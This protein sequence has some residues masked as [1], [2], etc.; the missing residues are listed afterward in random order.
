MQKQGHIASAFD[1]D[2]QSIQA[3]I[4]KMG[5]LVETAIAD[6]ARALEMRDVELAEQVRRN[7]KLIDALEEEVAAEVARVIAMRSP[8][9]GDLRTVLSVLKISGNL[10]RVGDY[11]KNLG[12]RT[13]VLSEMPAVSGSGAAI[14]RMTKDVGVML[15][16]SLDSYIQRDVELAHDVRN[17]DADVDQMYNALFRQ[18]LTHMMEDPRNITPCMHLHFIAKNI[19]RMGDHVTSIAEQVIYLVTGEMP[20][21]ERDKQDRTS[22]VSN[23]EL[24]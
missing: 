2:L 1:R 9:A 23:P 6:S 13:A 20:D 18:F 16:D 7:D 19:E 17:R 12:K 21:D 24:N 14:R 3:L 8:T 15:K 4:M 22:Y 11:A 5:G 10:E